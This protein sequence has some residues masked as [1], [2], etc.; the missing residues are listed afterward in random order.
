[1]VIAEA[2]KW[3]LAEAMRAF[4]VRQQQQMAAIRDQAMHSHHDDLAAY[5]K[6]KSDTAQRLHELMQYSTKQQDALLWKL[7]DVYRATIEQEDM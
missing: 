1:M 4:I 2:G 5:C 6:L 3:E 7:R